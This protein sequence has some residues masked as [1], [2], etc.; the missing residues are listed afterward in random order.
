MIGNAHLDPVWLWQWQEGFQEVKATFRSALDRLREYDDFIFTSSSAVFYEWIEENAPD[1]FEE[2]RER[3]KE[4]RWIIEGG[5][6]IQ[7]DLNIPSGESCV[8]QGLYGQRY[9]KEKFGVTSHTGYNVD[10]FGHNGMLPQILR[11]SGM[12][13]YIFM[14]PGRHEKGLPGETFLWRSQDESEVM[15]FRLPFEYCTWPNELEEHIRRCAGEIKDPDNA[16]MCFYGVG[17]HGGGPTK[18]NIESIRKLDGAEGFPALKMSSPGEYFDELRASGRELPVI[19]G[20]LLHHSTGCYSVHSKIKKLN[21][22]AE[23]RLE[24]AE[25][26]SVMASALTGSVYPLEEYGKSWKRVLFSQFHDIMAGTSIEPAYEDAE[27][28]YGASLHQSAEALNSAVQSVSW[29]INIPAEQDMKPI[30]IFN[31]NGFACKAEVEMES[32]ELKENTVLVDEKDEPVPLQPVRSKA[33]C[34]GRVRLCFIAE[35]PSMG[36]RTYRLVIRQTKKE[37]KNVEATDSSASNDWFK[38]DWNKEDGY[39]NSL[40][41]KGDAA[42]YFSAPAAVPVVIEDKNDTWAHGIIRYEKEI[43]RFKAVSVKRTEHGPVKS[44]I[45]VISEYESSRLIQEFSVYR[46]LDYIS[47]KTTVDW[48]EKQAML[49]LQFPMSFNYFKGTCEIP[50]GTVNRDPNGEEFPMQTFMDME[51]IAPGEGNRIMGLSILNDGKYSMSANNK[52]AAI[53]ILRSPVY[54]HHEPYELDDGLEYTYI[55]QGVQEFTYVL[56][57]HRGSWEEADTVKRAKLLNQKPTALFETYHDGPLAQTNSFFEVNRDNIILSA[58]KLAEDGS[59][60][61][62]LRL[63]ETA[64]RH[65]NAEIIL[66]ALGRT[67]NAEFGPCEIKTLR[68]PKNPDFEPVETNMLEE[69]E[70]R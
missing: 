59:G 3:V 45:R 34:K 47:V 21:R 19:Y 46:E 68:V 40:R 56:Y 33:S 28:S 53:T 23:N 4:K 6:W 12:E 11:K 10:G 29:K 32:L 17:N 9:F 7:P 54:A 18:L 44:V 38:V 52:L 13:N 2:I 27:Q 43:G 14:R 5:W 67:I 22:M 61:I 63:Y 24:A 26:M 1:M 69:M 39:I 50:Y 37:F 42:E 62:I 20:E 64:K 30:V 31:T 36:Y 48:H 70:E 16:I 66:P 58:M 35:L 57:P 15:A 65:T 49:K 60:D 55:D 41:L 8:R 51:G 25:K